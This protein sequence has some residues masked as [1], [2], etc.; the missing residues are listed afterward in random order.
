MLMILRTGAN[1][2]HK[3]LN[4]TAIKKTRRRGKNKVRGKA[5]EQS[6]SAE[7]PPEVEPPFN[8]INNPDTTMD[9]GE[10][11]IV[12]E[13]ISTIIGDDSIAIESGVIDIDEG[14]VDSIIQDMTGMSLDMNESIRPDNGE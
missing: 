3:R 5:S 9:V 14:A 1:K 12:I 2:H 4:N 8:A 11:S 13:D 7:V 10:T 6:T